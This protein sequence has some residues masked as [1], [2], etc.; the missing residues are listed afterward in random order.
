[1]ISDKIVIGG[2]L[3]ALVFAALNDYP[4]IFVEPKMPHIFENFEELRTMS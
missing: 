2:T 1:M 4:V 3:E